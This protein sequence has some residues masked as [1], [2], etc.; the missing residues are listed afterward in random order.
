TDTDGADLEAM[1]ACEGAFRELRV[2]GVLVEVPFAGSDAPV[3]NAFHNI[4]RVLRR[5]DF[6]LFSL[7]TMRYS[8]A[9]LPAQFER[10]A[11][12]QTVTGQVIWGDALYFRDAASPSFPALF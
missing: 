4:D 8:R 10:A 12:S 1:L 3:A 7:S 11:P 6:S 5:N 9:A 2:L